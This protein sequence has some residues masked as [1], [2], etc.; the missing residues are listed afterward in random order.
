VTWRAA[1]SLTLAAEHRTIV[2]NAIRFWD[3]TR[4]SV[5]AAVVMPDHA[6]VLARPRPVDAENPSAVYDLG[7]ILHSVKGYSAQQINKLAGRQGS[8]WQDERYDRMV[9]DEREFEE[10]WGCILY[11]PVKSG[12]TAKPE[13]YTWLY[14]AGRAD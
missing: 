11:N 9:R 10:A 12:L 5:Y 8:V 6:H 1:D 7:K 14:Q 4:W 13:E 2:L 3:A